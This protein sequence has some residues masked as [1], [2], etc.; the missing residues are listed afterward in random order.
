MIFVEF[1]LEPTLQNL[2]EVRSFGIR[3]ISEDYSLT[4]CDGCEDFVLI[5]QLDNTG[6]T[7][8]SHVTSLR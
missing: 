3:M 4:F 7:W 6:A 1:V 5:Y 8:D 2:R